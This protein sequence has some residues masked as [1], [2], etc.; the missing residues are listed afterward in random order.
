MF[1]KRLDVLGFKSFADRTEVTVVPGVTAVVG[2]NG[3]G[4]SNIADAIR[5]VLGEQSARSLR[6]AKM[7][8][9]IFAGSQNRRAL[10]FCEVSLTLDNADGKLPVSYAEVTVTRRVYRNGDSEYLL[11]Q[12]ACRLRDISELF[13]DT[14]VGREAYSII[15]QG[16]IEEILSTRSE[17][18]RGIFEEAAG[19]VKFKTRRKEAERKLSDASQNVTRV[20]DILAEL[21]DQLE[22]LRERAERAIAYQSLS[23]SYRK[24]HIGVLTAEAENLQSRSRELQV[25]ADEQ[26]AVLQR[27][28]AHL[29]EIELQV[30]EKRTELEQVELAL[31]QAN[32]ELLTVTENYEQAEA[33]R[34]VASVKQEAALTALED[35]K[36]RHEEVEQQLG[37]L[38]RAIAASDEKRTA[39]AQRVAKHREALD[40][41]LMNL[42]EQGAMR[43]IKERTQEAR[44]A[45]IERMRDQAELNNAKRALEGERTALE[46]RRL[47]LREEAETLLRQWEE[48]HNLYERLC[49]EA[50]EDEQTHAL[51]HDEMVKCRERQREEEE[52]RRA[53]QGRLTELDQ[54]RVSI[55]SRLG[56]LEDLQNDLEGFSA[57]AK[58]ALVA[59]RSKKLEGIHGAIADLVDVPETYQLAIE[60][61]LGASVQHIVTER[62][63]DA[64][65][66]IEYLKRRQLGRATFLPVEVIKARRIPLQELQRVQSSSGFVGIASDLLNVKPAF[67][68]IIDSLLGNVIVVRA[69][70]EA[71]AIAR[72]LNYRYRIVTEQGDIVNAGGSMTGG[73]VGRRGTP[74]LGRTREIETLRAR[75]QENEAALEEV[76]QALKRCNDTINDLQSDGT[77]AAVRLGEFAQ[78][79][80][81]RQRQIERTLNMCNFIEEKKNAQRDEQQQLELEH[82]EIGIK[83]NA[84]ADKLHLLDEQVKLA[85][86]TVAAIEA[87]AEAVQANFA[88]RNEELTAQRVLLAEEEQTYLHEQSEF[89][90]LVQERARYLANKERM[91]QEISRAIALL[92]ELQSVQ[93]E[94]E[95]NS[96]GIASEREQRQAA[97]SDIR[98]SRLK[99]SEAL[100]S[101]E[102]EMDQIRE[103]CAK[104]EQRLHASE[105]TRSRVDTELEARLE[106][107]RDDYGLGYEL[108]SERYPLDAPLAQAKARHGELKRAM[109]TFGEVS[110]GAAEEYERVLERYTFLRDQEGDLERARTQLETLIAE[111][112]DEMAKRFKETFDEVRRHFQGV[113]QSLFGGGQA[114]LFLVDENAPLTCGIEVIAEPPGKKMQALSL[115][116][117]GERAL[118][119]LALMFAILRVKPV[120]FCV[121]DEVEAALDEANV[122]RFAS[123]LREFSAQTQFV[124]IT[125]R[126][127]TMESADVL[128]GVTM[129]ESGVSKLVSVRVLEEEPIEAVKEA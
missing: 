12:K 111:I 25:T 47:R 40:Q 46:R 103:A 56:V 45:L 120:P 1:L 71:N 54:E 121:L 118:T 82:D 70:P 74:I 63:R 37:Q 11:N 87:E 122:S 94:L 86:N 64:R 85:E 100:S 53:V 62:E 18:R 115:L 77:K 78:Q 88:G 43:K 55:R 83:Q 8:D 26:R 128:Y 3:S 52:K 126:R 106:T 124:V 107:L 98:A 92:A 89:E 23:E 39:S 28:S 113:F 4:K 105:I 72:A 48:T 93:K 80:A 58:A 59:A 22:P 36:Q 27:H 90:R 114:D 10:N 101:L 123:Y 32:R 119:A 81:N 68:Q 66:A 60:T 125:H 117:G 13:M 76:A 49:E 38:A 96:I 42:D 33:E 104:V 91:V 79:A 102:R 21:E 9:V 69:L 61:A 5:W 31:E 65:N 99:R 57:G 84:L 109:E 67:K 17:D 20:K 50:R 110:L 16:R 95:R 129:Q 44:S 15:G 30:N 112:D 97:L 75:A 7:E 14:G 35:L 24:L 6:G 127:G 73:S 34:R 116:S 2:P 41:A 51:Y 108:A 19:I 29:D